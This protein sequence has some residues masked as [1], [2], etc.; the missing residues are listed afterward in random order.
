MSWPTTADGEYYLFE[1][2]VRIP[3][4]TSTGAPILMLRPQ[5]GMGVGIPAIADGQDGTPAL[6]QEGAV[7]FTELAYDD[8]TPASLTIVEVSP[9][10]YTLQ[11]AL[12]AGAPGDDGS[13]SID[14]DTIDGDAAAGR[15]IR[16]NSSVDGFEFT[17]ER[18][19]EVCRP[20][21]INN[22]AAGNPTSTLATVAIP[23]RPYDRKVI[24]FGYTIVTQNGGANVIVDMYARLDGE[25]G[26]N[27]VGIC[28]GVGGTERL[29]IVPAS[30]A[31]AVDTFDKVLANNAATVYFRAEQQSGSNSYTTSASTTRASVLVVPV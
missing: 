17:P 9:G 15:L 7:D 21:T 18:V 14:L 5:G 12:H 1:G 31:G 22:T 27:I 10:L 8:A 29:T 16:V 2:I 28:Q 30:A 20:V 3:V 11:G 26:G 13:T 6:F 23:S 24:P 25:S 19:A 4:P